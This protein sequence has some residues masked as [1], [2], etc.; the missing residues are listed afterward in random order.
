MCVWVGGG[1][2]LVLLV[3]P[4]LLKKRLFYIWEQSISHCR[5]WNSQ[6][7]IVRMCASRCISLSVFKIMAECTQCV[8]YFSLIFIGIL[9]V[10][11]VGIATK[12]MF[13]KISLHCYETLQLCPNT[14]SFYAKLDRVYA[15]AI[16]S[17]Y[18]YCVY[19][20]TRSGPFHLA[21]TVIC[22][23][24]QKVEGHFAVTII[25]GNDRAMELCPI[26]SLFLKYITR[27]YLLQQQSRLF[28]CHR[29]CDQLRVSIVSNFDKW[30]KPSLVLKT[31]LP[32]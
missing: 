18:C 23:G 7:N 1:G 30:S 9:T 2:K 15:L 32:I 14:W 24:V 27:K 21:A 22:A 12:G 19:M 13:D 8:G 16:L 31:M 4:F 6:P 26:Y 28:F 5:I 17:H 29:R 10:S 25:P 20:Y 11:I 3:V